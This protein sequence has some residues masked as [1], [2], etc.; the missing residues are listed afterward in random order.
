MTMRAVIIGGGIT[1]TLTA[2]ALMKSGWD[3]VICE[4]MHVGAG[5]SS[6]TAAGIRQQFSTPGT[7]CGM[8][9]SVDFYRRFRELVGGEDAA[10][11]QSGYL[12]LSGDE[13]SWA[14]ARARVAMQQ[15]AGLTEVMALELDV[16]RERFPWVGDEGVVGGTFCPTDGFLYPA[17][18]YQEAARWVT[19]RGGTLLQG[20]MVTSAQ[21]DGGGSLTGVM[22]KKGL[23]E[24]DL[25]IDCT[26]AWTT[27]LAPL[28]GGVGLP[29]APLKRYLWFLK[30][31]GPMTPAQLAD[32]PL[33]IT[34]SGAYCRPENSETLLA[35]HAHPAVP[36]YEFTYEEQDTIE[37]DF[38]HKA[39]VESKA[40][41]TWAHLAE[42]LPPIG[43]FG[44]VTATTAGFYGTTPDH[45]P[46]LGFDPQVPNLMRLVGFSGH[47]AMF[48]P[49]TALV[50]QQ[51]AEKGSDLTHVDV[52]G[53]AV[54]LAPFA[55]GRELGHA[56]QM[57]I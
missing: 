47:G 55:L 38:T 49:F 1:G 11:K 35:G 45:N 24:G 3:V 20:A 26:N 23:V 5:S 17:T 56:E 22:T 19:E 8:R 4:A 40:F 51:L 46:F 37:P 36:M 33:T 43:E 54:D 53:V 25:F 29:V 16:L 57:V 41:E 34:P 2:R 21:D 14:E 32:M 9:Y 48:G 30:R 10:I 6:R 12:F 7:V 52:D 28:L 39:G 27:R 31:E 18:V 15:Q 50:A 13:E 42:V 44:G